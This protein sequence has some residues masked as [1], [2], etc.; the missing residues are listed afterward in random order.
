MAFSI[1][2]LKSHEKKRMCLAVFLGFLT[3][4]AK[5]RT[6]KNYSELKTYNP[7]KRVEYEITDVNTHFIKKEKR[8]SNVLDGL[9]SDA[10]TFESLFRA[11]EF[12]K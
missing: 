6:T 2:A 12:V 11:S 4:N 10:E 9:W 3:E 7:S 5:N 1:K 8:K